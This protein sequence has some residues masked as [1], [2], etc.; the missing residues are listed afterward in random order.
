MEE[1]ILAQDIAAPSQRVDPAL[2]R[3]LGEP[4]RR[5]ARG[6]RGDLDAIVLKAMAR[7]PAQRYASA[8]A[9]ADDLRRWLDG[10]PVLAQGLGRWYV[11]SR[12]LRRHRWGVAGVAGVV[13]ALSVGL[14]TALWQAD[15]ARS[16][17]RAAQAT[18]RFLLELFRTNGID[19]DDPAQAQLTTARTLLE[20]GSQR[21]GG[22]LAEAPETRLRML[23]AL[24]RL[25]TDLGLVD[26]VDGLEQQ[27]LALWRE[28]HPRDAQG[29]AERL[30]AAGHAAALGNTRTADAGRLLD[31]AEQAMDRAGLPASAPQRGYLALARVEAVDADQ[32]AAL[33]QA[34]LAIA[35]LRPV[36]EAD[37]RWLDALTAGTRS[38][39][40]CGDGDEALMLGREA[41]AYVEHHPV[42]AHPDIVHQALSLAY[43]RKGLP[44]EAIAESREALRQVQARQPPELPP[45]TEVLIDA[46]FL[47]S[48]LRDYAHPAD[49]LA[50]SGPLL[51]RVGAKPSDPDAAVGLWIDH[52]RALRELGRLDEAREALAQAERLLPTYEVEDGQ[53][54]MLLDALADVLSA[55]GRIA[56][57]TRGFDDAWRLHEMLH[58]SGTS[59]VFPHLARRVAHELRQG[60][61]DAAAELM[62]RF[63]MKTPPS[64]TSTHPYIE[65]QVLLGE[66]AQARR[67]WRAVEAS[68]T[69]ALAR[70]AVYAEPEYA[71]DLQAR[72][73]EL[74]A[75]A[76]R[77]TGRAAQAVAAQR[78]AQALRR[79][80]AAPSS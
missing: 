33:K 35:L 40:Y 56:E 78:D 52:G 60:R 38:A 63:V 6:L 50:V 79:A 37:P 8:D 10:R 47:A 64:G 76:W 36:A 39:A 71:R 19:Q 41:L 48:K 13:A 70:Y 23:D 2:A 73:L 22:A 21:M 3:L 61:V 7:E 46:T 43:L 27:R 77:A 75:A 51:A 45:G 18:E 24:I 59:Q 5:V 1:A 12:L 26:A 16:E 67:D 4:V 65:R 20:R 74:Q 57:A 9:L 29:L 14:G 55:Q 30:I 34:R 53:R 42:G 80:L 72:A 62:G 31:E 58:H 11:A 69:E 28:L 25:D 32:C 49:A 66:V 54:A 17:A 15:R 44:A 68:A